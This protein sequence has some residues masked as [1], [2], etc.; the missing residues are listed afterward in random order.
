M[1][2]I[3]G[4]VDSGATDCFMGPTFVKRMQLGKRPLQ[5]PQKIWNIDN[6]KNKAGLIT[7]YV[8]LSIHVMF[9]PL[10]TLLEMYTHAGALTDDILDLKPLQDMPTD[11]D[12]HY[13]THGD[14]EEEATVCAMLSAE[15]DP[16]EAIKQCLH[17]GG[18]YVEEIIDD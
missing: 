8:D 5:K 10:P 7:H 9:W 13:W 18:A 11:K 1:A 17:C 2:D 3:K 15:E 4:L 12:I 6:T 16:Y 14:D